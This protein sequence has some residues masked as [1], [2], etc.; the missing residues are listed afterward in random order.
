MRPVDWRWQRAVVLKTKEEP[1]LSYEDTLTKRAIKYLKAKAD[2]K[3]DGYLAKKW[4]I[5]YEVDL[6]YSEAG[7]HRWLLEAM[8]M[9]GQTVKQVSSFFGYTNI[10]VVDYYSKLR[11]DVVKRLG[12]DGFIATKVIDS[13][14]Y[15]SIPPAQEKI[16]KALAWTGYKAKMSNKLLLGQLFIHNMS[17]EVRQWYDQFIKDQFHRKATNTMFRCD[18]GRHELM[19]TTVS[20]FATLKRLDMEQR[21]SGALLASSEADKSNKKLIDNLT[22]STFKLDKG[23]DEPR[24]LTSFE[25]R[26]EKQLELE[27]EEAIKSGKILENK[28]EEND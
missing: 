9:S 24:V 26:Y 16:W 2:G 20:S 21:N 1:D 25:P 19:H 5:V 15:G 28:N 17:Q 18:P 12:V 4:P 10:K 8:L 22:I 27:I 6:I 3:S 7:E 14:T 13:V 11:F 23:A